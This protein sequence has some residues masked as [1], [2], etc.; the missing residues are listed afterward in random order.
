MDFMNRK[1]PESIKSKAVRLL[2]HIESSIP[3]T[4]RTCAF[5]I[6]FSVT[7]TSL[8]GQKDFQSGFVVL[9]SGDT[10]KGFIDA[11]KSK[12]NFQLCIFRKSKNEVAVTYHPA[13]LSIYQFTHGKRFSSIMREEDSMG[14]FAELILSGKA[15]LLY[16]GSKFF[17]KNDHGLFP[18]VY[19]KKIVA[20]GNKTYYK[21]NNAYKEVL[22]KEFNDCPDV[23]DQL[24]KMN[25][26]YGELHG[27]TKAYNQCI[28]SPIEEYD[29]R[30][31][32][33]VSYKAMLGFVLTDLAYYATN[34]ISQLGN[35][36]FVPSS[37]ITFGIGAQVYSPRKNDRLK[38]EAELF[39]IN[40]SFS[41][42]SEYQSLRTYIYD[43]NV[44]VKS[45]KVPLGVSYSFVNGNVG[46]YIKSGLMLEKLFQPNM[47]GTKK[48]ISFGS[49]FTE[50]YSFD[51]FKSKM[52][53]YWGS[54]GYSFA[55]NEKASAYIEFRGEKTNGYL[56]TSNPSTSGV[57]TFGVV[58]GINFKGK[59]K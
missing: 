2:K 17:L 34:Q 37:S 16:D 53:G 32:I 49:E 18:L 55:L 56:G 39:Y 54:V 21:V 38:I 12:R 5:L 45:L 33:K 22:Y 25:Y 51:K 9:S 20:E 6:V 28:G 48:T 14:V 23:R 59:G 44:L 58:S 46:P 31:W 3:N 19:D 7:V 29:M 52:V 26:Y 36:A 43:I 42:H 8:H 13:D 35:S 11:A 27:L 41:W 40:N 24:V 1:V 47:I 57:S 30:P 15:T 4:F 50:P 10:L